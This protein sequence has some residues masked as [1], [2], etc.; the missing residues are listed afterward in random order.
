MQ[1]FLF[2]LQFRPQFAGN[3]NA[4]YSFTS[5]DAANT[6]L[7]SP[8]CYPGMP[9]YIEGTDKTY[10]ANKDLTKWIPTSNGSGIIII[11][12]YT[13]FPNVTEDT[14]VCIKNDRS[15]LQTDPVKVYRKGLY[16]YDSTLGEWVPLNGDIV[17]SYEATFDSPEKVW[18]VQHG[19]NT[20]IPSRVYIYDADGNEIVLP[21]IEYKTMN[22]LV[23]TY[24]VPVAGGVVVIK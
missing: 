3:L 15:D 21:N 18:T 7:S 4:Y 12:D 8:L 17:V 9:I 14:L 13:K 19:L 6:F 23:I 11:D 20:T 1:D 10:Y 16:L 5:E 24:D 22:L 2:P